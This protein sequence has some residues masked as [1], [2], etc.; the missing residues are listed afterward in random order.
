MAWHAKP[1]DS[2][3]LP[4][5][6]TQ[7][8]EA[9]DNASEISAQL[10]G[11]SWTA[12][13][14]FAAIGN[15]CGEGGLNPHRWQDDDVPDSLA[16]FNAWMNSS[17][18]DYHGYGLWGWTPGDRYIN[19]INQQA[20]MNQG[21]APQIYIGVGMA[22]DGR[23]QTAF[24][25]DKLSD[26]WGFGQENYNYYHD[27]F[28]AAGY[29]INNFYWLYS[30]EFK[31]GIYSST[32]NYPSKAGQTIPLEYMVGAFMLCFEK[33]WVNPDDPTDIAIGSAGYTDRVA[34]AQYFAGVPPTPPTPPTPTTTK[35]P[36]WMK[37]KPIWKLY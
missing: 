29:D 26:Y 24:L 19:N 20:Y 14:T 17:Q 1:Y 7:P 25:N 18:A 36:L 10:Q 16:E 30:S 6:Q 27:A 21:Y 33:P 9:I 12:N 23:A 35:M 2:Y 8:A 28:Y 3:L 13:A 31:S 4:I 5:G 32:G 34:Y 15:T 22:S 37:I 11:L